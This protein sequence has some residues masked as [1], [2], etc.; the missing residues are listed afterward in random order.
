MD[1][2]DL[3]VVE[4][5]KTAMTHVSGV[6]DVTEIRVRWLGHRMQAEIN[7][8]VDPKLHVDEAHEIAKEAEHHL[9]HHLKYLSYAIIHIDP[10]NASGEKYHQSTD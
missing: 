6:Q 8:A 1:G 9:L 3:S 2:V 10:V 5:I 4:E 7:I